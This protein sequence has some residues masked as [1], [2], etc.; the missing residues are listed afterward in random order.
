[1][2][3]LAANGVT[4]NGKRQPGR[5]PYVDKVF[6]ADKELTSLRLGTVEEDPEWHAMREISRS[7]GTPD[8]K[9]YVVRCKIQ[10][11]HGLHCDEGTSSARL[12]C[13]NHV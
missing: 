10:G 13:S 12:R 4:A 2:K 8:N 6:D 7:S 11:C 3:V 5:R 9:Q 1:M